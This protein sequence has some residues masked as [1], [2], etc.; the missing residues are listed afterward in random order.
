MAADGEVVNARRVVMRYSEAFKRE[1]VEAIDSGRLA[2]CEAARRRYGIKGA[3]TV[4]SWVLR[5]GKNEL[6]GKVVRV[7]KPGER[8][9]LTKARERIRQ[10]EALLCDKELDRA[11]L[12]A[13]LKIACEQLGTEPGAFKKKQPGRR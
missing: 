13:H 8:D 11:L 7:E 5:F 9:E 10:L 3:R 12:E 2:S 6:L 1:V 4:R